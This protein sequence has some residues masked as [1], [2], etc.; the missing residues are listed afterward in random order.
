MK[1][2][3]TTW[4]MALSIIAIGV[5]SGLLLIAYSEVDDAPGGALL[6]IVLAIGSVALGVRTARGKM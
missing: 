2:T 6:G 1:F 4:V 5:A 3:V